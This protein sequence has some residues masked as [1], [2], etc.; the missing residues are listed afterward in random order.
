MK[1]K[2][3]PRCVDRDQVR[4]WQR[5]LKTRGIYSGSIDG[6]SEGATAAATQNY[7]KKTGKRDDDLFCL[8]LER[9]D[10]EHFSAQGAE[11]TGAIDAVLRP[12]AY[13][14]YL[15]TDKDLVVTSGLRTPA[16]QAH[17][18]YKK[19]RQNK[20]ALSRLYSKHELLTPILKA[21]E[22]KAKAGAGEHAT[23]DAMA[24]VIQAQV[25]GRAYI[26]RHLTGHAF[27]VRNRTMNHCEKEVFE[28]VIKLVLGST[29]GHLI[30]NEAGEPHF[31]VQF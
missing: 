5:Y 20:S 21:Y 6:K 13:G 2:Q 17:E 31:H 1:L 16:K 14:Y 11:R 7:Q 24:A 3:L 19:A 28:A 26:S 18:M 4:V 22:E 27:D 15:M 30:E 10:K 29:Q 12:V 25:N 8:S 23:I 9:P